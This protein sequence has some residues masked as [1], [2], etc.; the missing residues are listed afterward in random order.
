MSDFTVCAMSPSFVWHD[1]FIR[2]AVSIPEGSDAGTPILLCAPWLIYFCDMTHSYMSQ[3][4]FEKAAMQALPFHCVCRDSL[5][6]VTCLIYVCR[7]EQLRRHNAGTSFSLCVPWLIYFCDMTYSYL[8]HNSCVCATVSILEGSNAGSSF[9][10]FAPWFIHLRDMTYSYVLQWA[11]RRAV[12][13]ALYSHCVCHDSF[14]SVTWLIHICDMTH[15]YMLQWAFWRAVMQA[16]CSRWWC[17]DSFASVTRIFY[18]CEK[19]HSYVSH[20]HSRG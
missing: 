8:W 15:S 10:L 7:S 2:A 18:M 5:M 6:C 19:T 13:Q 9:S 17:H 20:E 3:W 14:I 12:M 1:S 11:S 4:T 16:L